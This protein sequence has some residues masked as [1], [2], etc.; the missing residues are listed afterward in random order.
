M[1]KSIYIPYN[2]IIYYI[3]ITAE[4]KF[5]LQFFVTFF[6]KPKDSKAFQN[7]MFFL[8]YTYVYNITSIVFICICN[9]P[10]GSGIYNMTERYRT[11]GFNVVYCY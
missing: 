4:L 8:K 10:G 2:A 6:L 5:Y 9:F 3:Y 11:Y 7:K 1:I